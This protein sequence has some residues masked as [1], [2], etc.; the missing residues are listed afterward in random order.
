MN[1]YEDHFYILT[2]KDGATNFKVMR[3]H[4]TSTEQSHW[5]EFI[6]HRPEVL[7]EDISIF[8]DFYVLS[9]RSHGLTR[10]FIQPWDANNGGITFLLTVRHTPLMWVLIRSLTPIY[11]ALDTIH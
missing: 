6:P 5:E 10:I 8:K 11:C 2:N 1:H 3:A 4:E 7:V 9:E